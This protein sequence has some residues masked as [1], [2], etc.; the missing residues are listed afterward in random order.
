M[1]LVDRIQKLEKSIVDH[2][3]EIGERRLGWT[4]L[5][6]VKSNIDYTIVDGQDW[7][8]EYFKE[9]SAMHEELKRQCN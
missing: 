4:K 6:N 3:K 2:Y 5:K 9:L 8:V 7:N 1:H